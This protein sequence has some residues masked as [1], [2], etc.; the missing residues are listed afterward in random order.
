MLEFEEQQGVTV[1]RIRHG[2]V[3]ALDVELLDAL[4]GAMSDLESAPAVVLTGTGPVFS[5]GADLDRIGAGGRAYAKEFLDALSLTCMAVF[6]H[7]R[8]VVTAINGHAVAGGCVLA[9][10]GDLRIMAQGTIGLSELGVGVP[11]PTAALEIMRHATGSALQRMVMSAAL[12]T[13][14]QAL[15]LGLVDQVVEQP[16]RLSAVA[17]DAAARLAAVSA[18][19]FTF[20]K[21]QLHRPV[22]ERIAAAEGDDRFVEDAWSSDAVQESIRGYLEG[23][24]RPS[25]DAART[26]GAA[27]TPGSGAARPPR[28]DAVSARKPLRRQAE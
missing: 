19:V 27:H 11:F 6:D 7:P 13:P 10:A 4:R 25:P 9:A 18:E 20:S 15:S 3:N 22:H 17:V 5:A 23:L 21:R 16:D 14:R 1:V 26:R 8:P 28:P 12:L 2:K 24:R